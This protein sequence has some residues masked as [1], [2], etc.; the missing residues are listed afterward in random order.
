[1]WTVGFYTRPSPKH[2]NGSAYPATANSDQTLFVLCI[3]WLSRSSNWPWWIYMTHHQ[4]TGTRDFPRPECSGFSCYVLTW[5]CLFCEF[6][7]NGMAMVKCPTST[8]A[9]T[10]N[11]HWLGKNMLM[12]CWEIW[13]V[14]AHEMLYFRRKCTNFEKN[15]SGGQ[16]R[17]EEEETGNLGFFFSTYDYK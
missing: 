8:S 11:K 17:K 2:G 4:R 14:H 16:G 1:M 6:S 7:L 3:P 9:S 13:Q 15:F 5:F 12:S 10:V